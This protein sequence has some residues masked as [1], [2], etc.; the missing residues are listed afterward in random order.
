MLH[1][2]EVYLNIDRNGPWVIGLSQALGL[3]DSDLDDLFIS[4][5]SI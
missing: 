1:S 4:A 5:S 3:S 2:L